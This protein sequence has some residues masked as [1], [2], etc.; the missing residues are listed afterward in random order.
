MMHRFLP[1]AL[2]ASLL[3]PV[4]AALAQQ[5]PPPRIVVIGEGESA[6]PPDLALLSLTVMREA[7]TA[8]EALD[9]GNAAMAAVI[10]AM[11]SA[12]IADRDLQTGGLQISPRYTY[13]NK[14]D[15]TQEATLVGY[16][17]ANTL[18]VRVRDLGKTGDI[19]DK[20]V[21][22]G[23]NQGGNISFA[24]EDASKA[25]TD[26]RKRAVADAV[27]KARTLS[28]A[29]GVTL[30]RVLEIT[31]QNY[32]SPPM[33]ITAKAFDSAG[34]QAVPV[35]AGENAYRVQVTMTFELR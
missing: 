15:G 11:K 10:A 24:N 16:Q 1:V 12:G 33:P 19:L 8:R 20:A 5:V 9:A 18:S 17:V 6:I 28:E 29:A 4:P 2:A 22:L 26:A 13:V 27:A 32:A 35:E 25:L 23:V 7:K 34:A 14:P 31:D 21:T 3:A 30:G